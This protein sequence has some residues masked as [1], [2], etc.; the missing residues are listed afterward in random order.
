MRDASGQMYMRNRYYDPQTGQFTQTDPIGLAGG[1]NAYGFA[2]GD[3][4]TYS[5]PYG[6]CA[7]HQFRKHGLLGGL[8]IG[9]TTCPGGLSRRQ[10]RGVESAA[11][12]LSG[13]A[14]GR[15]TGMLESGAIR[16]VRR[17][18]NGEH[19]G[20]AWQGPDRIQVT[21]GFFGNNEGYKT[22]GERAW[23]LGHE[24]GHLV[25]AETG[26]LLYEPTL[27]SV[28]KYLDARGGGL[29]EAAQ[30]D[31]NK[32]A[33]NNTTQGQRGGREGHCTP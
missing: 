16:R 24:L 21:D 4:V 17:T 13:E 9:R 19:A 31:A 1:L 22:D 3:P 12:L 27:H 18:G 5:D 10:Y 32:Y 23:V 8:G 14:G 20:A 25:Q 2:A 33:C 26:G 6:L 28:G 29:H 7:D 11:G 15:I 30:R